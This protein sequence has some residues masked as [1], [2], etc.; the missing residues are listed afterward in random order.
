VIEFLCPN[1]HRIHCP[2]EQAGRAAKCPRCG[3]KFRI[4]QPSEVEPLGVGEGGPDAGRVDLSDSGI[5][6]PVPV[7]QAAPD[8]ESL[9]EFLCPNGHRLHGPVSLQGQP[10]ECPE[11]GSRFRI[12]TYG[13][14]P[15]DAP[16]AQQL[17]VGKAD[18]SAGSAVGSS[19]D[20]PRPQPGKAAGSLQS[21]TAKIPRSAVPSAATSAVP[22]GHPLAQLVGVLWTEKA[23]GA[24][25]VLQFSGGETLVPDQFAA[26]LSRGTHGLFGVKEADGKY[27][28]TAVAW[29]KV[30]RIQVRG[31]ENVPW[32]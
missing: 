5:P 14:V 3:V 10:G 25:I 1:G 6:P 18:G 26:N 16:A 19:A 8:N 23:K 2:E 28:L 13:D 4:P 9:I 30:E 15:S 29:D 12:P 17:G 32:G 11:C 31:A 21:D 20:R 22:E 24:T 27:T 7:P